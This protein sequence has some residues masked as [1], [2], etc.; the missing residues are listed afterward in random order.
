M[1]HADSLASVVLSCCVPMCED[2]RSRL[3]TS[4]LVGCGQQVRIED[5]VICGTDGPEVISSGVP[6]DVAAVEQLVGSDAQPL[7]TPM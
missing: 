3:I 6:S 7:L 2:C 5:D 1:T 4:V